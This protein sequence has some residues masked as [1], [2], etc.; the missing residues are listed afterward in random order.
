MTFLRLLGP[1]LAFATAAAAA[2]RPNIL[3]IVAGDLG[4]GDIG[5]HGGRDAPT[6]NIDALAALSRAWDEWN[7]RNLAPLWHG[8][9]NEDPTAPPAA[10]AAKSKS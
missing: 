10:P 5:V 2:P 8:S 3:V 1:L 4:Y 7:A 6:P 9:P